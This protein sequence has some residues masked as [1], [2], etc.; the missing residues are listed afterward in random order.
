MQI[1]SPKQW[2]E[3]RD[4]CGGTGEKLEEAKEDC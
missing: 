4:P 2:N 1:I 3:D